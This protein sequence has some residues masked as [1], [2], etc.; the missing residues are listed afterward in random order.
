MNSKW[1]KNTCGNALMIIAI[2]SALLVFY[3]FIIDG[4]ALKARISESNLQTNLIRIHQ[5][6]NCDKKPEIVLVGSSMGGRLD[7]KYFAKEGFQIANLGLDGSRPI[8]SLELLLNE[9]KLP[10]TILIEGNTIFWDYTGNDASITKEMGSP[11]FQL[12]KR[13]PLLSPD[14]RFS[15]IIF[16]KLKDLKESKGK[17]MLVEYKGANSGTT[18][19]RPKLFDD[20][21]GLIQKLRE[22]GCSIIV[23]IIPSGT[24]E[25]D[26]TA[27]QSLSS[28]TGVPLLQVRD[29]LPDHGNR[30]RYSDGMHLSD[31]SAKDVVHGLAV[32]MKKLGFL[33][34]SEPVSLKAPQTQ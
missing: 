2:S 24:R 10:R 1:G 14:A 15:S 30:L 27:I 28:E 12:G 29:F 22:K 25:S 20:A 6:L 19:S 7:A 8:Y 32:G 26:P 17:G 33:P 3:Y 5:Y 18:R 11:T 13:I 4:L 16:S 31:E 34:D 23:V 9:K 21:A